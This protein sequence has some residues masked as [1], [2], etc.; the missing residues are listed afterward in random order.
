VKRPVRWLADI[1]GL[2]LFVLLSLAMTWPLILHL[3]DHVPSDLG[4]PLY[5]VW[6][7]G[8]NVQALEDGS[9]FGQ[10]NIFYPHRNTAYYG[11]VLPVETVLAWP[12]GRL[13]GNYVLAYN[14]LFLLS[15]FLAAASM[16]ALVRRLAQ[17]RRAAVLSGLIF[18]FCV[19]RFAHLAHLELL[20]FAWIPL[21]L[22]YI[23]RFF[24][25]LAWSDLL[26][27]ALFYLLQVWSCAYYG[28][29]F[30]IFVWFIFIFYIIQK[31]LYLES[32][33]WLRAGIVA[34]LCAAVL[35]WYFLPFI[36]LHSAMHFV[37]PLWEVQQFSAQLQHFLAVPQQSTVWGRLLGH[38]GGPETQLYP[39]LVPLFLTLALW[40]T[41]A[42]P[43]TAR[44][45]EKKR[46][47][48]FLW[49]DV[50]NGIWFAA[51]LAIGLSGGF[52]FDLAGLSISARHAD[53][54]FLA[55]FVSVALRVILD[56]ELRRRWQASW[57][58][59]PP[60][61]RLYFLFLALS[62]I[63]CLG[64]QVKIFNRTLG[65]GLYGL[66]YDWVPGFRRLPV[67]RALRVPARFAALMMLA[68][69]VL[70]GWGLVRL[71][72]RW[73]SRRGRAAFAAALAMVALAEAAMLPLPLA[74]VRVGRNIP[75]V[76]DVVRALP[77]QAVLLELPMPSS[78]AEEFHESLPMYYSLY[79]RKRI[80]NGYNGYAPP[81][82]RII[83]E[84]MEDFPSAAT[85]K[86]LRDLE[87]TAV[88]IHTRGYREEWGK[89]AVLDMSAFPEETEL[90]AR[91]AEGD[92]L[93]RIRP[94]APEKGEAGAV[95]LSSRGNPG[96]WTAR[97]NRNPQ[98]TGLAFDGRESTAWT[99][100][101]SQFPGDF[102]EVD[103][104]EDLDMERLEMDLDGDPLDFPRGFVLEGSS[105]GLTWRRLAERRRCWPEITARSVEDFSSY[106]VVV[107]FERQRVRRLRL[108]LTRGHPRHWTIRELRCLG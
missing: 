81:G 96:R 74:A 31:R 35:A 46:K 9:P 100:G 63:L 53:R 45:P 44:P 13:T 93:Y 105:D 30:T 12:I 23:H 86:L 39:G 95:Q 21:C 11:D 98:L 16:Y 10:A 4:D 6:L 3:N 71:Q 56:K 77:K 75:A 106:K 55:L 102:F 69:A 59:W 38:L 87:V 7:L 90:A 64:P 2:M 36:R 47:R 19:F 94:Q 73:R 40:F 18:A 26:I 17:S 76:Y 28:V 52:R 14:L 84:A 60:L 32:R 72:R 54:P 34:V 37:R 107:S 78:D 24:D 15:F 70:S 43:G 68:L 20:F 25:S 5:T 92:T 108:T 66:L 1:P 62:W 80:V 65:P 99:T 101:Y 33:F 49:W 50:L 103:L 83:R 82:Y 8:R 58:A 42:R 91:S 27:A 41:R 88:L 79:H 85:F 22:L 57:K 29:Y 89:R 51:V 104:A 61:E 48:F 97:A 67:F